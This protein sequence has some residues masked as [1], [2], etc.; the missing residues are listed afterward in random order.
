MNFGLSNDWSLA[1]A[2]NRCASAAELGVER[3][4]H[5]LLR[6]RRSGVLLVLALA[7]RRRFGARLCRRGR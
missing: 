1:M 4:G 6:R 7:S 3:V 2:A 5:L